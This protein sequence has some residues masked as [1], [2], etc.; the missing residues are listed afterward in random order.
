V[1]AAV[2]FLIEEQKQRGCKQSSMLRLSVVNADS[3]GA[4]LWTS[5][6]ANSSSAHVTM[7]CLTAWPST[8]L[9]MGTPNAKPSVLNLVAAI[10]AHAH[11]AADL[12]PHVIAAAC[13]R[14]PWALG[15]SLPVTRMLPPAAQVGFGMDTNVEA[16]AAALTSENAPSQDTRTDHAAV[17]TVPAEPFRPTAHAALA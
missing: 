3:F 13:G 4:T 8:A 15:T 5:C 16:L 2:V 7:G 1:V 10:A 9:G 12:D 14:P 6:H 17:G 11:V